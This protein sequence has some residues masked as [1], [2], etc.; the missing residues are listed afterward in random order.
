MQSGIAPPNEKL[1]NPSLD[2]RARELEPT[3]RG[4]QKGKMLGAITNGVRKRAPA[5]VA[6]LPAAL[7]V[8]L[9][10]AAST[11]GHGLENC[12]HCWNGR[13]EWTRTID[14]LRVREAL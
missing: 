9:T 1:Q 5:I 12:V 6:E 14:L 3:C 2:D 11:T 8:G 4:E 13:P 7:E 10:A